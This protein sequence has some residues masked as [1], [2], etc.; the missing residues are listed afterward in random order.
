MTSAEVRNEATAQ[1]LL[2]PPTTRGVG[3]KARGRRTAAMVEGGV[4]AGELT[5]ELRVSCPVLFSAEIVGNARSSTPK[6]RRPGVLFYCRVPF[7][8]PRY[9]QDAA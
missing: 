3:G 4:A 7:F 9:Y 1:D 2:E 5:D 6:G 8:T